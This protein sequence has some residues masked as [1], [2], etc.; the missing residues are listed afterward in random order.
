M[1]LLQTIASGL[2]GDAAFAGGAPAAAL[3][4]ACHDLV[5]WGWAAALALSAARR[6]ALVRQPLPAIVAFGVLVFLG[7]RL[8]V[9]PLSAYPYPVTFKPLGTVLDLASHVLLFAGPIVLAVRRA[10]F[11]A[12]TT[13]PA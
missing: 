9:L 7:M 6:P 3:G 11:P 2:L 10:L 8:V 1:R 12:L 13:A 5:S 4:F